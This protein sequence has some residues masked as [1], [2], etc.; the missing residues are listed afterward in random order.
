MGQSWEDT[1]PLRSRDGEYR[2][3]LSRAFPIRDKNGEVFLWCGT[4]TDVTERFD[5]EAKQRRF[6]REMLFGFTEGRLRLCDT[7]ADL[8]VPLPPLSESM[9][10]SAPVLRLLRKRVEAVGEGLRLP[11]ERLQDMITAVHEA[12][13]NA[14]RHGGGGIA[15]IHGDSDMGTLQV[16]VEDQGPGIGEELIHR[17]V[18]QGFTTGGFGQGFFLMRSCADRVYL[19]TGGTGTIIVL[20]MERQMPEPAWLQAAKSLA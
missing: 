5:M 6:L 11:K 18:E 10:M 19:K 9:Q 15:R 7:E 12:A 13:M 17:A 3:F 16:W 20:E 8:P 1:F 2:W 4:N 14:V